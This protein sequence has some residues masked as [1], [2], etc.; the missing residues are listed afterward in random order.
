MA[1][2]T[3]SLLCPRC[4]WTPEADP[5]DP[6]V[7]P[8][9][10]AW[11]VAADELEQAGDD[12]LLGSVVAG[13]YAVVGKIG[14]GGMGAVYRAIQQP[15]G[16]SV[17][18]KVISQHDRDDEAL[19]ARFEQEARVVA[20]LTPPNCVTQFDFGWEADGT[21]FMALE[22]VDGDTLAEVIA[23]E[24]PLDSVRACRIAAGALD[25]L[26]E[27]HAAGL[28]H[29]DL[30]PANIMLAETK[31]GTEG[32]KVLDFG[33]AKLRKDAPGGPTT[34]P[35]YVLGTA[36]YMSPE[37]TEAREL[38]G[39]SDLY[40]MGV[41]LYECLAGAPPFSGDNMIVTMRLHRMER[42]PDLDRE[43]GVSRRIEEVAL[44][45][46]EKR[47]DDRFRNARTMAAALR[48]AAGLGPE[49]VG[50]TSGGTLARPPGSSSNAATRVEPRRSGTPTAPLPDAQ[51][52]KT[53]KTVPA[54]P[55]F[56]AGDPPR[57]RRSPWLLPLALVVVAGAAGAWMLLAP[58]PPDAGRLPRPETTTG[59]AP[60]VLVSPPEAPEPDAAAPDAAEPT[61]SPVERPTGPRPVRPTPAPAAAVLPPRAD[62]GTRPP[63]SG[64]AVTDEP[65][66]PVRPPGEGETTAASPCSLQAVEEALAAGRADKPLLAACE[67]L[68]AGAP[69]SPDIH[70]KLARL[71]FQHKAWKAQLGALERATRVGKYRYDP[72]LLLSLVKTALKVRDFGR[73]LAAKDR[74]WQVRDR[75][76]AGERKQRVSEMCVLFAQAYEHRFYRQQER[77]PDGDHLPLLDRAR[78]MWEEYI[79]YSGDADGKGKKGLETVRRLKADLDY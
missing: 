63:G 25:A 17:A 75:L 39:R 58:P 43:L 5:P 78:D 15:V 46:L 52:A 11:L 67:A 12:E 64:G 10:G 13:R 34:L 79:S 27:A 60:E 51:S 30:K 72:A 48:E 41:V 76:P 7:C 37:M 35:G 1:E 47:P 23:R 26:V 31:W 6:P 32:V 65:T 38:D 40:A 20:E 73:A 49:V 77:D 54:Q 50:D 42:P 33:I 68:P 9:D 29:R 22:L 8:E 55:V 69:D 2:S 16:R 57:R 62:A 61:T 24:A 44:R 4:R 21:L 18:L 36:S 45:A 59:A 14:E 28:V 71:H 19:A 56:P 74:L 66:E 53:R 3:S 70:L